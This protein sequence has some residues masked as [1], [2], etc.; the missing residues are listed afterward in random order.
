MD[1]KELIETYRNYANRWESGEQLL[2]SGAM[3]IQDTLREAADAIEAL[4]AEWDAAIDDIQR[5]CIN[6]A[7]SESNNSNHTPCEFIEF[8]S[9]AEHWKW[10]GPQKGK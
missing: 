4:L 1:Y 7:Y 10:R 2:L 6:C 8:C 3:R 5:N 9:F